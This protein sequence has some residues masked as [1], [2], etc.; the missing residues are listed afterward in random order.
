MS[1]WRD[2]YKVHPAADV[3]S[4]MSD[5]EL[6]ELGVDIKANGIR[7]PITFDSD[8]L[9]IDGRNRLEAAERV[10]YKPHAWEF[11]HYLGDPVA[12][13]ISQNIRRRH[14]TKQQQADLIVAVIAA[15]IRERIR[16]AELCRAS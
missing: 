13:I 2:K 10:G 14:L 16:E 11:G 9:L 7:N 6:A 1:T 3:F 4:M 5:E 15:F 12:F 8:C